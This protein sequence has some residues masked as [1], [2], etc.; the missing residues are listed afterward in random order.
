MLAV[1]IRNMF[2]PLLGT[3]ILAFAVGACAGGGGETQPTSTPLSPTIPTGPTATSAPP[4][5]ATP[6][7]TATSL[8]SR[9]R[10]VPTEAPSPT[11]TPLPAKTD[12]ATSTPQPTSQPTPG[13][14]PEPT[15]PPATAVTPT[16]GPGPT[17]RPTPTPAAPQ[18]VWRIGLLEDV[19]TT[20]IW[21]VLGRAPR[22]SNFYVFLNQYPTLYRLSD[23]NLN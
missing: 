3:L 23:F 2:K 12:T 15:G 20:N 5:T 1:G 4:P 6:A 16:A 10:A 18:K 19:T 11:P 7:P 21:A 14:T 22:T 17:Q 8:I 9:M 13:P